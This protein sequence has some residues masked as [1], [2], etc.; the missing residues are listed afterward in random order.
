MLLLLSSSL[1]SWKQNIFNYNIQTLPFLRVTS[2][3][4]NVVVKTM[5]LYDSLLQNDGALN[6]FVF[7]WT[8]L[9]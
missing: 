6:S 8:T 1:T 9:G 4:S 7:F 5:L 2:E 3:F